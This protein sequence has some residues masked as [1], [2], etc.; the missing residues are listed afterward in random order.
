MKNYHVDIR[1]K[2]RKAIRKLDK[3]IRDRV[4]DF[5]EN[6]LAKIRALTEGTWLIFPMRIGVIASAIIEFLPI[7]KTTK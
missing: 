4:M 5:I 1:K 6:K 2:A 7:F 3:V